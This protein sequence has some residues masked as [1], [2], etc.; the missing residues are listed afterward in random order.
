M[1]LALGF[2]ALA[3]CS[4]AVAFSALSASLLVAGC[5]S[6]PTASERAARTHTLVLKQESA[7][8]E[9][10]AVTAD[11]GGRVF[12][13]GLVPQLTA[14][15]GLTGVQLGY[16]QQALGSSV[17][18]QLVPFTS[19][20]AEG[21]ALAAGRLDGAYLDPVTAVRVWLASGRKLIK[22]LAGAAGARTG[23]SG[24]VTRAVLVVTTTLLR[25]RP[26]VVAAIVKGQIQAEQVLVTEPA[27]HCR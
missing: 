2:D 6:A 17:R 20:A 22:V 26:A 15:A 13:L 7:A 4:K 8:K 12:R 25:N 14:A 23:S 18:L 19:S 3:P 16:F 21:H 11:G 1:N 10:L 5:A 27:E 9:R 24:E